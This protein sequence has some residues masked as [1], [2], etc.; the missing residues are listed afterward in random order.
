MVKARGHQAKSPQ[1]TAGTEPGPKWDTGQ[2]RAVSHFERNKKDNWE[3][4]IGQSLQSQGAD[5]IEDST[6]A[7]CSCSTSLLGFRVEVN[8]CRERQ[9]AMGNIYLPFLTNWNLIFTKR[10]LFS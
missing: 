1:I 10:I 5:D 2:R 8:V 6:A 7:P 4:R 3:Q 9:E